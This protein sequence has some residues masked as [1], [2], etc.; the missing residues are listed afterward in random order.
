M[1]FDLYAHLSDAWMVGHGLDLLNSPFFKVYRK[2]IIK[3]KEDKQF[4]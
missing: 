3:V 1:D 4:M 2:Q